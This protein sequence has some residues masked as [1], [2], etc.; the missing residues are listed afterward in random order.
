MFDIEWL[1]KILCFL[2]MLLE[3]QVEV[4]FEVL[5]INMLCGLCDCVLFELFYVIGLCVF[6][7]VNFKLFELSLYDGVVCIR[8]KGN[9]E[10]LVLFGQEVVV[11][12]YCYLIEVWLELLEGQISDYVFVGEGIGIG[13]M[14]QMVWVLIKK[15]VFIVGILSEKILLYVLWYVFVIYLFNYGVDLCVVQLLFGYVDIFMMQVYMYV[16][17]ECLK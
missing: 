3:V 17:C 16:V 11:W 14:C 9:K 1:M 13:F 6:E 10:C 8:G 5:D 12:L 15:Y 2:K 7:F 4:L